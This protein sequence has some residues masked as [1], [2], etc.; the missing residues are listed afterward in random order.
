MMKKSKRS[1]LQSRSGIILRNIVVIGLIVN[2][3]VFLAYPLIMA[4]I[5]S[6][7]DWNA[8]IGSINIIGTDHYIRLFNDT[9]FWRS[10]W[11]TFIF[12]VVVTIARGTIGLLIAVAIYSS[13][14]KYKSIFRTIFYMPVITPLVAISFVWMW[15]YNPQIGL[16]NQLLGTR[17][18]WLLNPTYALP[19]IMFMMTW[20]DF[21]FAVIIFLAGLYSMP[22]DCYEAAYIDGANGRNV[23]RFITMPLLKPITFFVIIT[24]IIAYLQT[25]VPIFVMTSGG[26]GTM[27]YVIS[28]LI[29]HEAFNNF[30][31]G[32]AS[33][34]ALVLFVFIA[35]LTF[36]SFKVARGVGG[37]E[38]MQ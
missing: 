2:Y 11:N 12:T 30:N 22:K 18:N 26:P 38:V 9:L 25:F 19:S 20:K 16:A 23:F 34:L 31:F 1:P 15:I 8:L 14:I 29:Y 6:F 10:M 28:Y 37:N 36:I 33:A 13:L 35:S 32:Y 24:S 3:A 17:I 5:G 27:T 7:S 4:F 21:G